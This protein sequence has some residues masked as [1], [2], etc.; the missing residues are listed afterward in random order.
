MSN[1]SHALPDM[2][3][4]IAQWGAGLS[5]SAIPAPAL[6][7]ARTCIRDGLGVMLA[8]CVTD[9]F[10][11]CAT[12]PR[13]TGPCELADGT[14]GADVHTAALLNGTAGHALDFDDT[15][16]AGIVHGTAAVLPAALA[17]AQH[18]NAQG[19]Q[20]LE[21]F[22]VGVET[23]YALGLALTNSLYERG[24]WTT[25]TLGIVGAAAASAKLLGLDVE[26][27]AHAIRL[28][29]NQ[30]MG[31]RATHGA[32][33]KPYLCGMA[34][35]SG[36]ESAYAARAGIAGQPGTFER[37]RGYAGTLNGGIL[38][39]AAI[40]ALGSRYALLD[41]G[42]AFKLRP[43]C[44]AVQAAIE[45]VI[46]LQTQHRWTLD[47]VVSICCHG[48]PL[49]ITSL[50]YQKPKQPGEAQFSMPFAI[51]CTLLHGDVRIS[52]L[53]DATLAD[54]ALQHLMQRVTLRQD[55]ALVPP[56]HA[57]SCPEAARVDIHLADGR[58]LSHTVLAAT[59]MPQQP[60]SEKTMQDKFIACASHVHSPEQAQA[61]W[62]RLQ[63][64]DRLTDLRHLLRGPGHIG[65]A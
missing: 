33:A 37:P 4:H 38:D 46:A 47:Q 7:V 30:P 28:A 63:D 9:V 61:L 54:P 15:C 52:H 11:K 2:E 45:A 39:L 36:I 14:A 35:R 25:A 65:R 21:A 19:A 40:Q 41:P 22:V 59:G 43:M 12:L 57:T 64:L 3:S 17:V 48:T 5:L 29:A 62:L 53:N 34:A 55:K 16:Y 50:P 23:E 32:T 18:T 20:L 26:A 60:A 44:S 27:T 51:A 58:Q 13:Y 8:G 49:V 10:A 6:S 56:E 31:L 42:I 1:A 24:H